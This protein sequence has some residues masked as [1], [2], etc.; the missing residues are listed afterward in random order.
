MAAIIILINYANLSFKSS[1]SAEFGW[2]WLYSRLSSNP[3]VLALYWVRLRIPSFWV[4]REVRILNM[5]MNSL[6]NSHWS[7]EE[8]NDSWFLLP[9]LLNCNDCY[10]RTGSLHGYPLSQM[11]LLH[12]FQCFISKVLL[13]FLLPPPVPS[14]S[15]ISPLGREPTLIK[16]LRNFGTVT[17]CRPTIWTEAGMNVGVAVKNLRQGSTKQIKLPQLLSPLAFTSYLKLLGWNL[18]IFLALSNIQE[19]TTCAQVRG[20]FVQ[21]ELKCRVPAWR[22]PEPEEKVWEN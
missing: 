17:N 2:W 8:L 13:S 12:P 18:L 19:G 4:G 16:P 3:A 10:N 1:T 15:L 20:N 21:A 22:G 5:V 6:S 9:S 7:Q 14:F 11:R